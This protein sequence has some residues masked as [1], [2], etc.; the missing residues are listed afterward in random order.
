[1]S[2]DLQK[3]KDI[4]AQ[5]IYEKTHI[6][7]V[8]VQALLHENFDGM[9]R[10]QFLGFISIIERDY[11]VNLDDLRLKGEEYFS[12]EILPENNYNEELLKI[13]RSNSKKIYLFLVMILLVI[14]AYFMI[15]KQNESEKNTKLI[16]E[17]IVENLKTI[18]DKNQT[19]EAQSSIDT[20]TTALTPDENNTMQIQKEEK[21]DQSFVIYPKSKVW[22]GYIDLGTHKKRQTTFK[23]KLELDPNKE[24]LLTFGHGHID[25]EINGELHHFNKRNHL[26]FLYKDSELK[27]VS[28]EEF[29]KLN[30]G[31][32]W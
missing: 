24:W 12:K 22:L 14:G 4:G 6:A 16:D 30:R 21:V 8:H 7:H 19:Q 32:E 27:A 9:Q 29:K 13:Q 2:E 17:S 28:E 23:D 31:S 18:I 26:K 20:N 11:H 3:L 25:I 15:N 10:V 5:K 1:M